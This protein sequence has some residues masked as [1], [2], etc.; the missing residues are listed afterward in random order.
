M[1]S[2]ASE[3]GIDEA[4]IV[5]EQGADPAGERIDREHD[6][7][8]RPIVFVPDES[9]APAVAARL[10]EE[11]IDLIELYGGFGPTSAAA[12]TAAID[13]RVPVGFVTFGI[14]SMTA[15]AASHA[16]LRRGEPVHWGIVDDAPAH[17]AGRLLR[18]RGPQRR[19]LVHVSDPAD[20][21]RAAA[22][23]VDEGVTLIELPGGFE[24]T[25]VASVIAAVD[26]R[27]PVGVVSY[28]VEA[29]AGAA[30]YKARFEALLEGS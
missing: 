24:T 25:A 3:P 16:A 11:G 23:L 21:G 2:A 1:T 6:G 12:V 30:A 13:G 14:E 26:R 22:A 8:R 20:A 18:S 9:A 4:Y 17:Q 10:V 27:V 29:L 7:Q 19:T 28:G 15:A 5:V